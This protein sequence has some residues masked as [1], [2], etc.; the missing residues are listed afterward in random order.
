MSRKLY[1]KDIYADFKRAFPRLS[2]NAVWWQPAGYC[3]ISIRF[4]DG[5]TMVYDYISKRGSYVAVS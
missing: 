1:Y 3:S 5:A 4:N 2:Q